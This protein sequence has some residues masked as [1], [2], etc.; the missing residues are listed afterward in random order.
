MAAR[1][2]VHSHP[3]AAGEEPFDG[4]F[5]GGAEPVP[6]FGREHRLG[7]DDSIEVA[8][9]RCA[10]GDERG[11]QSKLA[12]AAAN[13]ARD[14]RSRARSSARAW[15]LPATASVFRRARRMVRRSVTRSIHARSSRATRRRGAAEPVGIG[16]A[17]MPATAQFS[18]PKPSRDAEAQNDEDRVNAASCWLPMPYR[19]R[20]ALCGGS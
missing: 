16:W 14:A 12:S 11:E 3:R 2:S 17:K 8:L 19:E 10:R 4:R 7:R 20:T 15:T 5:R 9:V 18:H 1:R 13:M 6:A